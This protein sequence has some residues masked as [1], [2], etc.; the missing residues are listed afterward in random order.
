MSLHEQLTLA[1][2]QIIDAH[3][4]AEV[5]SPSSVAYALRDRYTTGPLEPVFD[6]ASIEHFKQMARRALSGRYD[7]DSDESEA[8]QGELFSGL[9]T[10]YPLPHGRGEEASYKLLDLMSDDEI[11]WNAAVLEKSADARMIHAR[12]LRIY[13]L[14][15]GARA[16]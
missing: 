4:A 5:I 3:G 14:S 1:I 10:R 13:R 6:Y 8:H 15:R 2:G 16:A 12:K 11:E 9:Q 7:A